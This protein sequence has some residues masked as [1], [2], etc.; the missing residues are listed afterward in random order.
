M[1]ASHASY[2]IHCELERDVIFLFLFDN[3]SQVDQFL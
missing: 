2:I 1:Y 3:S